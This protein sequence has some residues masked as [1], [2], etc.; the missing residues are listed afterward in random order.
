MFSFF[1]KTFDRF[2]SDLIIITLLN[3]NYYLIYQ[4][5]LLCQCF[6]VYL[7]LEALDIKMQFGTNLCVYVCP[8]KSSLGKSKY[9]IKSMHSIYV[10][11]NSN[12]V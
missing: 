8:R 1:H 4:K 2:T 7:V 12:I 9:N 5:L 10:C 3:A 11:L 6:V